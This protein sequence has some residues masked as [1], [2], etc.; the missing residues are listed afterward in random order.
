[1]KNNGYDELL[2]KPEQVLKE[3]LMIDYSYVA[4]RLR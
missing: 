2:A 4:S 1:M 3:P